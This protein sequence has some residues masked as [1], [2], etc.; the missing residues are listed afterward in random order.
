MPTPLEA[1]ANLDSIITKARIDL[2]KPIQVAEVL[3]HS[4]VLKSIDVSNLATYKNP[5][6]KWRNEVS[7]RLLGK[8]STSSA[9]YQHNLWNDNAMPIEPLVELDKENK[10]T[11]GLVERYIYAKFA[12][13][14]S[15]VAGI[16]SAIKV[17]SP[18]SFQLAELL[19]LFVKSTGMNRSIDKAYEIV[20]F[21]VFET[22][23]TAF[24]AIVRVSVP[25]DRA[26]ILAEFSDLAKTLLGLEEGSLSWDMPAHIYRVGVTNAADRGL[27]MWANFGPAIQVKHLTLDEDLAKTI[28]DQIE[29]DHIVVVC[30]TQDESVIRVLA[31]QIGWG[32][33]VR[34]IVT[35]A[36]LIR[37]YDK[38]LRGVF[39]SDLAA[40]L[41]ERLVQGFAAEFPQLNAIGAFIE[42]RGY[43]KLGPDEIWHTTMEH[44][45]APG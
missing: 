43:D 40:P 4:R 16:F 29:S 2:Y 12:E 26:P 11:N 10:R 39:S 32:A 20:T 8:S 42:E 5:S 34:G 21:A 35:E 13:K 36:D 27:D 18:E 44:E 45:I 25:E 6:I 28:V 41:M 30:R 15:T 22:V 3:W 19:G 9:Q 31:K 23:V 7:I 14:Q 24:S 17:A 38:C 37:W 33:R 1:K